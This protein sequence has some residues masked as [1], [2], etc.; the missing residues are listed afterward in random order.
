VRG[1]C[2][3]SN[4]G[5]AACLNAAARASKRP[6][7]VV[8]AC[9]ALAL[10]FLEEASGLGPS[11]PLWLWPEERRLCSADAVVQLA[12]RVARRGRGDACLVT[13]WVL[14]AAAKAPPS[15]C[16]PLRRLALGF[17]RAAVVY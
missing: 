10:S 11:H 17:P 8:P 7:D 14:W 15:R 9:T 12:L 16:L 1:L 4:Q 13:W 2:V 6:A 5:F 3:P